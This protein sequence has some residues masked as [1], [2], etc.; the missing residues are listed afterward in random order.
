MIFDI[1]NLND[2][3]IVKNIGQHIKKKREIMWLTQGK[4]AEIMDISITTISRLE[5]GQQCMS[6]KNLI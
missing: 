4:L 3:E 2:T 5:N 6:V 1:D